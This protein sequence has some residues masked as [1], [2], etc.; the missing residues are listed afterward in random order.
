MRLALI[1]LLLIPLLA[2]PAMAAEPGAV[3][4]NCHAVSSGEPKRR[5]PTLVGVVGRPVASVPGFDYSP[6]MK[7]K[8]GVWDAA[9]LDAF[10]KDPKAA[11]PD[12]DMVFGGLDKPEDR[13]AVIR[14]LETLK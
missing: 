1:A 13:A 7:A 11:I 10:L 14:W 6:A 9:A 4:S 2:R 5:G 8:G 12:N 3:C